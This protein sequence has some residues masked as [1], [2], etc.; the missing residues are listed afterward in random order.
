MMALEC[1]GFGPVPASVM[2]I[3]IS[4]GQRG[5]LITRVPFTKDASGRLLQKTLFWLGLSKTAND[6]TTEPELVECY[7]TNMVKSRVLTK[8]GKNRLPNLKE[9]EYWWPHL[10]TEIKDV[11]PKRI[12]ALGQQVH[13]LLQRKGIEHRTV[14]HPRWYQS[15]GGL[16]YTNGDTFNLMLAD[17]RTALL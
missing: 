15:H 2:I 10:K 17:Y 12:L 6:K 16:S 3:G 5:A 9:I 7:I 11:R 14:K 1:D 13:E 4:A 8:E